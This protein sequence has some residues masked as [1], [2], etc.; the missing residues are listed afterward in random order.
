MIL[1]CN[2]TIF[3]GL[4]PTSF[5]FGV[6]ELYYLTLTAVGG[7]TFFLPVSAIDGAT[8]NE[9][10]RKLLQNTDNTDCLFMGCTGLGAA[11]A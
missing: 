2:A 4:N 7:A 1:L 10:V 9:T 6:G 8:K 5:P 3:A 11:V